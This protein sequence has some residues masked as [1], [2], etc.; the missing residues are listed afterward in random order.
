[1]HYGACAHTYSI[2]ARDPRSGQFGV[3]VQSHWFSTGTVVPWAEPGVGAVATQAFADPG[4]GP[5]ALAMMRAGASAAEALDAL[6]DAD[7]NRELRQVAI[8][9]A[10]G[11]VAAHTGA[12][13]IAEAG[14]TLG[15]QFSVQANMMLR[16]TVWPAMADAFRRARGDLAERLLQALEAAEAEGGDIRGMQSAAL[17]IVPAQPGTEPWRDRIFDLRIDDH[18]RPLAELRRLVDVAR[19]CQE[20]DRAEAAFARSDFDAAASGYERAERLIG[21]NPEMHFW[22]GIALINAGRFDDAKPH[23]A[24]AFARDPN[25]LE[26]ALRLPKVGLMRDDSDLRNRLLALAAAREQ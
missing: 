9:D 4:Y 26:L 21:D 14:H 8:V 1:M 22:H 11:R 3:A 10:A 7:A 18:P 24:H 5:R 20:R 17:V 19:A 23:L 15:E 6:R 25:W 13:T 2:V 16:A 12:R